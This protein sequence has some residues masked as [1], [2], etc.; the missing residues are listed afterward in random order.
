MVTLYGAADRQRIALCDETLIYVCK[1]G[2]GR[3]VD[4]SIVDLNGTQK[5]HAAG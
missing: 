2:R 3:E 5:V 1:T 4:A